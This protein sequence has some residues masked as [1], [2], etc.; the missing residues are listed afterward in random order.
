MDSDLR[1]RLG[2]IELDTDSSNI[3]EALRIVLDT[4][5]KLIKKDK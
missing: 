3:N 2:Y 5:D 1:K 4:Y